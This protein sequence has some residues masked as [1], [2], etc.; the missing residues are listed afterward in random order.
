MIPRAAGVVAARLVD[1]DRQVG[2]LLGDV[3]ADDRPASVA[4]S[5][6]SS[7]PVSA[8]VAGVKSGSSKASAS[9]MPGRIGD[10]ADG[11]ACAW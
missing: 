6:F 9:A 1:A 10:P 7:W 3:A 8:F 5:M 11:A 2:D 4:K